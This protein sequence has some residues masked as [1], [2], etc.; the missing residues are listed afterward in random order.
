MIKLKI[1]GMR[2]DTNILEVAALCP[3]YMGFIFYTKSPRYVGEEFKIPD[4]PPSINRVGVFVNAPVPFML[5]K[6]KDHQLTYVQLHGDETV[7]QCGA[8]RTHNIGVIKVFSVGDGFDFGLT[9]PYEAVSDFF[10]FDTKGKYYGGNAVTF[11]WTMLDRYDQRVPFFLS[12]GIGPDNIEAI[13]GLKNMNIHAVDVNS[14]VE[15][16]PALKDIQ[17]INTITHILN[18]IS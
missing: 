8:L 17:K 4:L 15:E 2:D 18:S 9:K 16:R 12:G 5:Q 10:L 11:D 13:R 6:A 14:G 1:C 3:E 7:E